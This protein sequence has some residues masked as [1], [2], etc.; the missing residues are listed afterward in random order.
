MAIL[1]ALVLLLVFVSPI[2]AVNASEDLKDFLLQFNVLDKYPYHLL[3]EQYRAYFR[4]GEIY[5]SVG[6]EEL[7][8]LYEEQN[9]HMEEFSTRNLT[10]LSRSDS[11]VFTSVTYEYDWTAQIGNTTMSGKLTTH[12]V[13]EKTEDGWNVLFD[14]VIQ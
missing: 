2:S 14:A 9:K 8:E 11:E 10:I 13:L 1:R 5:L 7:K 12:S 6:K 3:D 4:A